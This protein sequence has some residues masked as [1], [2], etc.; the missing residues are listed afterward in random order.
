MSGGVELVLIVALLI[1]SGVGVTLVFTICL[2]VL[3][4]AGDTGQKDPK[5]RKPA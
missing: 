5:P 1:G 3:L 2:I 4:D